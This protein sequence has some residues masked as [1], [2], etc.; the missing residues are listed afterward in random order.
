M[1]DKTLVAL[2]THTHTRINLKEVKRVDSIY[3]KNATQKL[4]DRLYF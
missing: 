3:S 2:H 1:I 4:R